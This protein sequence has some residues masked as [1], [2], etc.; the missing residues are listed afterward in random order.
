MRPAI[1]TGLSSVAFAIGGWVLPMRYPNLQ[2]WVADA[3]LWAAAAM[4]FIAVILWLWGLRKPNSSPTMPGSSGPNSPIIT[5]NDNTL[6]IGEGARIMGD[7]N[8]KGNF[9]G[10]NFGTQNYHEAPPQRSVGSTFA[11]MLAS[12]PAPVPVRTRSFGTEHEKKVL[13]SSINAAFQELG[14]EAGSQGM[15]GGGETFVGVR[16]NPAENQQSIDF[17]TVIANALSASGL[18]GVDLRAGNPA[19][20][21]Q[22]FVRIEIGE[23]G[24]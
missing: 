18:E 13:E 11:Q 2:P 24:A 23:N 16:V 4:L 21:T 20:S 22:S 12:A 1:I 15:F 5:G 19:W 17:A 6:A 10:N 3:L 8:R 14:F 7:D 9:A